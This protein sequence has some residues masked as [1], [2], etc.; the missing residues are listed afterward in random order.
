PPR[1]PQSGAPVEALDPG[2]GEGVGLGKAPDRAARDA[3]A[4]PQA[5]DVRV[6]VAAGGCDPL[7]VLLREPLHLPEPQP[8]REPAAP[9][10]L[11]R[12]VPVARVDADGPDRDTVRAG[13]ADDL[14]RRVEP[15]WLRVQERAGED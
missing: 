2:M 6:A 11:Q 7:A 8:E 13:I 14:R 4:A 12:A 9:V 5:L 10:R 3:G 1:L 15:H